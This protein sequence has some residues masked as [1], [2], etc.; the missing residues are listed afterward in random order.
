MVGHS[1]SKSSKCFISPEALKREGHR[2]LKQF[3]SELF[4][5]LRCEFECEAA[6]VLHA[7]EGGVIGVVL[8]RRVDAAA[9]L[10]LIHI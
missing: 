6:E 10:S 5:R 9:G 3:L 8:V 4:L 2:D 7:M 1:D